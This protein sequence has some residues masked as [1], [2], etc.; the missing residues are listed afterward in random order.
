MMGLPSWLHWIAWYINS[1]MTSAIS[2]L[3][4]VAL[5]SVSFKEGMVSTSKI[6]NI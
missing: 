2:I 1:A 6:K 4:I 5:V 3:I